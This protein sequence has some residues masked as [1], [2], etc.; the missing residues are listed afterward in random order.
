MALENDSARALGSDDNPFRVLGRVRLMVGLGGSNGP[1]AM[2]GPCVAQFKP[3]L[4][5]VSLR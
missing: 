2:I 3:R 1:E 4:I 5:S